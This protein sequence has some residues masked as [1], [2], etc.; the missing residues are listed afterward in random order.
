MGSTWSLIPI[1]KRLKVDANGLTAYQT[2]Y[3]WETPVPP[4][5]PERL[6]FR[7]CISSLENGL[8]VVDSSLNVLAIFIWAGRQ[9]LMRR[10]SPNSILA[11]SHTHGPHA[12]AF[13]RRIPG[14]VA[15]RAYPQIICG[16]L[17]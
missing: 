5:I 9:R 7:G 1:G 10:L 15:P 4:S 16:I 11:V 17:N 13:E 6:K 2:V 12:A 3:S 14:L 8:Q